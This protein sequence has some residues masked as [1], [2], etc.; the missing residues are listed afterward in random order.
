MKEFMTKMV[1]VNLSDFHLNAGCA[2]LAAGMSGKAC[3]W[4][5]WMLFGLPNI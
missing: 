5:V 2:A 1:P 4:R 3:R